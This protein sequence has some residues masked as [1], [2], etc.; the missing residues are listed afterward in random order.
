MPPLLRFIT[1][2]LLFVPVTLFVI[3]LTLYGMVMLTPPA[4]RATLYFPEGF[5]PDRLTQEKLQ[6]YTEQ[7]I[8][9][10]HLRDPF[11]VQ[12]ALWVTN[13]VRG[14]WGW[15]VILRESVLSALLRRTPVTA[16]LTIYSLLFF[17][18]MGIISGVNAA[19]KK[20]GMADHRFR[21]AAFLATT[22][23]P[24]VLA[25]VL[26]SIFYVLLRWFPPGRPGAG[27]HP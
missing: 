18:P 6:R 27:D 23:P 1:Y 19:R 2:R 7:I 12:Y 22:T 13:L 24:F 26:L 15:S 21:L 3:T 16:E 5:N 25:L 17:I 14:D 20:D 8:I 11:P 9:R 10:N 4:E